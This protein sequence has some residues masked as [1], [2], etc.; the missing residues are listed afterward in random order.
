MV[1]FIRKLLSVGRR[2]DPSGRLARAGQR[3]PRGWVLHSTTY[4]RTTHRQLG[5]SALPA[6]GLRTAGERPA[7]RCRPGFARRR[8]CY[9]SGPSS[10]APPARSPHAASQGPVRQRPC[11]PTTRSSLMPPARGPRT[12][13]ERPMRRPRRGSSPHRRG[14]GSPP[15][16]LLCLVRCTPPVHCFPASL[17]AAPPRPLAL[18]GAA[19]LLRTTG[20]FSPPCYDRR[21][22]L[23]ILVYIFASLEGMFCYNYSAD[24]YRNSRLRTSLDFFLL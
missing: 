17:A 22:L 9:P 24:L 21:I 18:G 2:I 1:L 20:V 3:T 7:G 15:M 16:A 11:Y 19:P 8:T 14:P 23:L 13:G 4:H 6:R 10:L 12:A 5:I